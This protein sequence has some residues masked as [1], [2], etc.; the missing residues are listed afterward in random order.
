MAINRIMLY[1]LTM[2]RT[3]MTRKFLGHDHFDETIWRMYFKLTIAFLTQS[4][5]QLEQSSSSSWAK[6]RFILDVYG[7]DMRIIMG[8]ELV[9]CW[10]LI[11]PFKI[12]FIPNLVGSFIDVTLV[13]EVEL[14]CAT[15]PIFYDMLMVDYMAN[16]NFKQ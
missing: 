2:L 16:G 14:R 8:S 5:L 3:I 1:S 9:S 15:I 12:S 13:P 7:Y 4:R 11:G 6:R 10:E